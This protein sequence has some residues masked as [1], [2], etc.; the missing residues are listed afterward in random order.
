MGGIS[1]TFSNKELNA[2]IL[3]GVES[4]DNNVSICYLFLFTRHL[5]CP[6]TMPAIRSLA[7]MSNFFHVAP[8]G[9]KLRWKLQR[10]KKSQR[11]A[12]IEPDTPRR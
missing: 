10:T 12:K 3:R 9:Q 7:K 6:G 1:S 2:L 5:L 8:I 4:E 11:F